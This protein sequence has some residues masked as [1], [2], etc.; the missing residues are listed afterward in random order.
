MINAA[1]WLG[2]YCH[3]I[4][5][6]VYMLILLHPNVGTPPK[7]KASLS[8]VCSHL[9]RSLTLD[10]S[11][12]ASFVVQIT[13]GSSDLYV[14]V[15]STSLHVIVVLQCIITP[16]LIVQV[17]LGNSDSCASLDDEQAIYICLS[18]DYIILTFDIS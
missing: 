12:G 10:P 5:T 4:H 13:L 8:L 7:A 2:Y 9:H 3:D 11:P 14:T 1:L 16:N 6:Y 18:H 17:V 15:L